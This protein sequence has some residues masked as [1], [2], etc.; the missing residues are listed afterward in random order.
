M[1]LEEARP[2]LLSTSLAPV[3]ISAHVHVVER[4]REGEDTELLK[5]VYEKTENIIRFENFT[6][7]V[8]RHSRAR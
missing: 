5:R 2:L 8:H 6:E 3:S 4:I 1:L 7:S